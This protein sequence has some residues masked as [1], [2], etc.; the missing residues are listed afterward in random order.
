[1]A[2]S[3]RTKKIFLGLFLLTSS[4]VSFSATT[5]F[6]ILNSADSVKN[7]ITIDKG[8]IEYLGV[9]KDPACHGRLSLSDLPGFNP[10]VKVGQES[11]AYFQFNIPMEE[12]VEEDVILR[13]RKVDDKGIDQVCSSNY[14]IRNSHQNLSGN[15]IKITETNDHFFCEFPVGASQKK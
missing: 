11:V 14:T 9:S 4:S 2:I 15:T 6:Y 7:P 13:I 5:T 3:V 8:E 1:M 10:Q 12:C